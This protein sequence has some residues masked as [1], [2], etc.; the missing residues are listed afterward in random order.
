M[1]WS[2]VSDDCGSV[3]LHD[4]EIS[5]WAFGKDIICEFDDG[6]DV[7]A[8]NPQNDTGRH[9]RTGKSEVVLKGAAYVSGELYS[10]G[11]TKT[12][13]MENL[14]EQELWVLDFRRLINSVTLA[15]DA[16]K[17]NKDAGFCTLEF[18]CAEVLYRW[19]EFTE[20]AWFQE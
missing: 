6:F 3:S 16:F 10:D 4:C 12:L 15:C 11:G 5:R 13:A 20:D 2:F 14:S 7:F 19:N 18:M 8:D 9:K 17:D 1:D